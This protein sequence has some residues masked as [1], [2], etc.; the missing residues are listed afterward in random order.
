MPFKFFKLSFADYVSLDFS[1]GVTYHSLKVALQ[2]KSFQNKANCI[3]F[4]FFLVFSI[5]S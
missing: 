1:T 5:R 3:F 2:F 4:L